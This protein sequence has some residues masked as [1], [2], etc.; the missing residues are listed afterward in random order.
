M[1]IH[2]QKALEILKN[3]GII[4]YP[5]DTTFGIGCGILFAKSISRIQEIKGRDTKKAISIACSSLEMANKYADLSGLPKGFLDQ[6][7]PG[8]VTLLLAK[9]NLVSDAITGG[10]HKVGLRIPNHPEILAIISELDC[11]IITT[12]ANLSGHKDPVKDSEVKLEVEYIYPGECPIKK[13][14]TIIDIESKK[15]LREGAD[16]DRYREALK[17]L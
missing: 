1:N 12:S 14:S 7:F 2:Q 3:G 10:S 6:I 16:C 9:T 13:P 17:L 15:I 8:P 11:P 4:A 5:T